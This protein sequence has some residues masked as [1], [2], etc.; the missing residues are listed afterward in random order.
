MSHSTM[1]KQETPSDDKTSESCQPIHT[2]LI[3]L[4]I[5]CSAALKELNGQ[6]E[7]KNDLRGY[8]QA[9]METHYKQTLKNLQQCVVTTCASS[10]QGDHQGRTGNMGD[11]R[12]GVGGPVGRPVVAAPCCPSASCPLQQRSAKRSARSGSS[13]QRCA[14]TSSVHNMNTS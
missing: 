8:V 11:T 6:T 2:C 3:T 10:G 14:C 7:T 1:T 5:K 12:E 13:G 9:T 4:R